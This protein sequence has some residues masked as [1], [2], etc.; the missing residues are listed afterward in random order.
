MQFCVLNFIYYEFILKYIL[1]IIF[2]LLYFLK[3]YYLNKLGI[4]KA[5]LVNLEESRRQTL[6]SQGFLTRNS[7]VKERRSLGS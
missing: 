2:S 1:D 6:K 5:L 3:F 4:S 7:L